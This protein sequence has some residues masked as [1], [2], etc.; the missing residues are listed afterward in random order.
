MPKDL[1]DSF[2]NA[3]LE[4]SLEYRRDQSQKSREQLLEKNTYNVEGSFKYRND[5]FQK[6]KGKL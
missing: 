5:Y 6:W 4:I 1:G 2:W 3:P